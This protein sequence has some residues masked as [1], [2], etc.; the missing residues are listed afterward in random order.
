MRRLALALAL[1]T[2][3]TGGSRPA[4]A[5]T[6]LDALESRVKS[7]PE[8]LQTAAEY[9]QQVITDRAYDRAIALFEHLTKRPG[10]G[11]HSY[12][13]LAFAYVDKVPV[14][15]SVRQAFLGRDAIRAL[16]RSIE[17]VPSELAFF[18]RGLVNLYYDR[19]MFHRTDKG[20]ADLE[21]AWRLAV[22]AHPGA[23]YLARILQT[24]GDG[25]FRLDQRDKARQTWRD[26]LALAPD[27]EP[28]RTRVEASEDQARA[29][30]AHAL[31][32]DVRVDTSL[33]ELNLSRP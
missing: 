10:A 31:D 30:V 9:R 3:A 16:T 19:A 28:L 22:T 2:L 8:S 20:V 4:A 6:T 17:L 25:Y 15:G 23:P 11:A 7:D 13:N 32:A 14:S 33:R 27:N 5:S 26:G 1:L 21:Q 24:L 18:V 12:L 29:I